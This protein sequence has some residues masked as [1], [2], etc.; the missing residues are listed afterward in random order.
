MSK[1]ATLIDKKKPD[2]EQTDI[3]Y[4]ELSI[5]PKRISFVENGFPKNTYNLN[6]IYIIDDGYKKGIRSATKEIKIDNEQDK[7]ELILAL[8][9]LGISL[10]EVRIGGKRKRKTRKSKRPRKSKKSKRKTNRKKI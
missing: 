4:D 10:N 2:T 6:E 8:S 7:K 3:K 1:T 5:N 9:P